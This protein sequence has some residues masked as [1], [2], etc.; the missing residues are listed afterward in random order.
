MEGRETVAKKARFSFEELV[1]YRK[2][3]A[4]AGKIYAL[5]KKYPRDELFGLTSQFRK[6]A[7]SMPLNIAEGSARTKKDFRRFL[8]MA[9]GSAYECVAILDISLG[10]KYIEVHIFEELRK[11]L[12]EISKMLSGLKRG[13]E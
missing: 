10:R 6:A 7:V 11:D 3:V 12:V 8:D 5:T 1:V 2:A 4:F 13:L 9:R